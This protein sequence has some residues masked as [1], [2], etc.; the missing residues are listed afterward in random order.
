MIA[1]DV[2]KVR[3]WIRWILVGIF[4]AVF[5]ICG[6]RLLDYYLE[7]EKQQSQ[8]QELADMV[9]QARPERPTIPATEPGAEPTEPA[10]T[11][12]PEPTQPQIL[13]AYAEI[14]ALNPDMVGWLTLE[15]SKI[16]YPVMQS[17]DRVDHYLYRD[18]YGNY[19]SHGCLYVREL[20]NVDK[21]SDNITI[22]G[23]NMKD[24]SM[25]A[26][27]MNYRS[28]SFWQNNRY[29]HF[30]TL[31]QYH[32]YEV[33]SVFITTASRGQGFTY[34]QFV[35][36]EDSAE[37]DAY[38]SKCKALSL[39]DTGITPVYGE[40]LITLSTCDYSVTNGRFVVV[41]RQVS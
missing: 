21:P 8:F 7:S 20:C 9:S 40:K 12:P 16:N 22:Y 18:F 2:M 25:L 11:D 41:A 35:D 4:A 14:S 37:Y 33:F 23:H 34:H 6:Y 17:P 39:Y 27:L 1:Q 5:L 29:I 30:D 3:K 32:T 28:K 13:Q 15:G 31:T 36:A 26:A 38:V 24:G 10:P 19:S